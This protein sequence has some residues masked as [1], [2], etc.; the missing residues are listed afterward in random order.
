MSPLLSGLLLSFAV[1]L[2]YVGFLKYLSSKQ[3]LSSNILRKLLH[4]GIGP[5]Y[6]L[7]W[8]L[9]GTSQL[10]PNCRY[11][12]S[13]VPAC[14]TLV[15]AVLGLG[16][17]KDRDLVNTMSRSGNK[18]EILH[19]PLIYGI[20]HVILTWVFW[21]THPAGV[22]ALCVLCGGD[23]TAELAGKKWGGLTGSIP[24]SKKKTWAG[25]ISFVVCSV[26]LACVVLG[27]VPVA[28][29]T[30]SLSDIKKLVVIAV[31]SS[32]VETLPFKE[33]DNATVTITA[34]VLSYLLF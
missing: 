7:A 1:A 29:W 14:V 24:W 3:V 17:I 23:G 20:M 2:S 10:H 33:I 27:F 4:I 13:I 11:V 9:Y 15:F 8:N 16:Y 28:R 5:V 12:A 19:G 31:G 32:V 34:A 6:M 26:V 25:S 22:I 21:E 18:E 30:G